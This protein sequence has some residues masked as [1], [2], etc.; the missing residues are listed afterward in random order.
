MLIRRSRGADR[1][2]FSTSGGVPHKVRPDARLCRKTTWKP[3]S[4]G[5]SQ[6]V[7]H[8]WYNYRRWGTR[9]WPALGVACKVSSTPGLLILRTTA[10][11][12]LLPTATSPVRRAYAFL[13][14]V[15]TSAYLLTTLRIML[16]GNRTEW[17]SSLWATISVRWL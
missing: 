8:C 9:G 1:A 16:E 6:R 10:D 15:L 14:E 7:N 4:R 5:L 17:W 11:A 2:S 13:F 3:Y 12:G